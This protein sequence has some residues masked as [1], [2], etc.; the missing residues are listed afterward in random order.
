MANKGQ[1]KRKD[2][3]RIVL[4]TGESQ[5]KN[6]SI[7][8]AGRIGMVIGITSMPRLWKNSGR[9]KSRLPMIRLRASRQKPG[10]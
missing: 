5:R 3:D 7:S 8:T 6:G 4:K 2:K 10:M 1:N 9:R